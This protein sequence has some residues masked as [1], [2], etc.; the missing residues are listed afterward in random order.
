MS[1]TP[2]PP[3]PAAPP[4]PASVPPPPAG[5]AGGTESPN[6]KI[7]LV[8]SYL[9]LL[10]LVPFFIEKEDKEVQ[11]H[12]KHGLVLLGAEFILWIVIFILQMIIGSI[13]GTLGCVFSIITGLLWLGLIGF[14]IYCI[15]QAFAGERF[16]IQGL[17]DF[18][19]RF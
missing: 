9:W 1:D 16:K 15:M 14:R 11:W 6:R 13:S 19:D 12:A 10:A 18:A 5:N 2:I 8:L 7:M 4:P 17:S 3:P